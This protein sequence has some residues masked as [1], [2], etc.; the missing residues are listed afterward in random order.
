MEFC[1]GK[2]QIVAQFCLQSYLANSF[3]YV[4]ASLVISIFL[5]LYTYDRK[6][7]LHFSEELESK[8]VVGTNV[9]FVLMIRVNSR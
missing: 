9:R 8:R 2:L 7:A 6:F 4:I 3:C 1:D 5:A